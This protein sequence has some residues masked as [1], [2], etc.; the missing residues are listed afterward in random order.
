MLVFMTLWH[1]LVYCPMAHAMW[2]KSGF[3]WKMGILDFAGGN[4]VHVAAGFSGLVS[5]LIV[6]NRKG[7]GR[8]S[9]A[10]HNMLLSVMGA[11]ML[12]IGWL[13]FNAGPAGK[14]GPQAAQAMLNT[15]VAAACGS[16]AWMSTEWVLKRRPSVFGIISGSLAGLIS[17]T[18]GAGYMDHTGASVCGFGA[19]VICYFSC[20]L[21]YR[22]NFD[23]ALDAF[24]IH[25]PAAIWGGILVGFFAKEEIGGCLDAQHCSK[26]CFEGNCKQVGLQLVGIIISILWSCVMTYIILKMVDMT[27]GLRVD[28]TAELLGLDTL[29]HGEKLGS[30]SANVSAS[31][32]GHHDTNN[33][34]L[35][36]EINE[37]QHPNN[38]RSSNWHTEKDDNNE[39]MHCSNGSKGNNENIELESEPE[40]HMCETSQKSAP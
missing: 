30:A 40:A 4:V 8:E 13:S 22:F 11:S 20:Q 12:W 17:V 1:L 6:G 23:D 36:Q 21:K 14:V 2:T 27:F 29:Q 10:A 34:W 37:S 3:L 28:E 25:G 5:S 39:E 16:I 38:A 26:G 35:Q 24:G 18:P 15:H 33:D 9:F 19:G 7:F 32:T 31:G